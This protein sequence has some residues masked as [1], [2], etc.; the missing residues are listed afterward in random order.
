MIERVTRP[1]DRR[2]AGDLSRSASGAIA[3]PGSGPEWVWRLS[4]AFRCRPEPVRPLQRGRPR[5]ASSARPPSPARRAPRW[6]R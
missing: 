3:G 6:R 2:A 1:G 5:S 4:R